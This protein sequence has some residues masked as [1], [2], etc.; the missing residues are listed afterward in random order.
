M[1][2]TSLAFVT[3][4]FA[5]QFAKPATHPVSDNG[6]AH[7]LGY[8]DAKP[9][10]FIVISPVENEQNKTGSSISLPPVGGQK[11]GPLGNDAVTAHIA[12]RRLG[13]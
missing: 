8:R 13:N 1:I 7:L 11:I 6:I 10:G 3:Q 4:Q 2:G 9:L 12:V 5:H